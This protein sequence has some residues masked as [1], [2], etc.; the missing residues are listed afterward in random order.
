MDDLRQRQEQMDEERRYGEELS[1]EHN[2]WLLQ[3]YL[4]TIENTE[5]AGI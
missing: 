3:E 2:E 1:R 4:S 5:G